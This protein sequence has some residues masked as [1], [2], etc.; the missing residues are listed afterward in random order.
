MS[1]KNKLSHEAYGGIN[2]ENYSPYVSVKDALPEL[3]IA[4]I[5][6]GCFFAAVFAAANVY[7][8]L[9]VGM[10][11]AAIIP[12]SILGTALLYLFGRKSILE[13][14]M[15]AGIA[16]IGE[17]LAGGIVFT[18]PAIVIWNGDISLL[19]IVTITILG[20]ILGI[21]FVIP[22]RKYL[23]VEEHGKLA[24]PESMAASEVLVNST[25]GGTGLKSVITG[26]AGGGI[27]K[28][29][30]GGLLLWSE[31]PTWMINISQN[32]KSIFQS[33]V[34]VDALASLLGVGFIV[35]TE[36]ALYMFAGGAIAYFGL[37]PLIK[38]FGSGA[39]AAV[40]PATVPI[41]E[42]TASAIRGEYIRYIGAGAVAAG[43]FISL[44]KSIPIIFR[45]MKAA[46]SGMKS[47]GEN[48]KRTDKDLPMTWVIG[49]AAL[50][51][52]LSWLLPIT[53]IHPVGAL[54][55][56]LFSFLFSVVSARICGII[57]ASNNP[58][59]GMTIATLLFITGI[60]KA[61][62]VVGNRGM[63]MALLAGAIA[64]VA[65]AVAGGT[66][67]ALK[68]TFILGGT[69]KNIELG[70]IVGL[71]VSA[72]AGGAAMLL[73][74]NI[75]GIGGE[76]GLQAPQATLMSMVV[77]GVMD[78]QLPWTLVLVGAAIGI[79]IE[80][81]GLPVLPVAL[82]IYLPINL[83]IGILAGG[84]VRVIV[85]KKF[86][87]DEEV[88]K[89]KVEKG[90]LISSGLVAGDALIGILV[91]ALTGFGLN[92]VVGI[93]PKFLPALAESKEFALVMF[94]ILIYL[95]YRYI[96]SNK[97]KESKAN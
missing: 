2:G 88:K 71:I 25:V 83:S 44:G 5:L 11:I 23:M 85:D 92:E 84:I 45:S 80:I 1:Q 3:T 49:G 43:G 55:A 57:G 30:S 12:T 36:A 87:H 95:V 31:S 77:Q 15:V 20:G 14:N 33:M 47:S 22:L 72:V 78:A 21:L 50:V 89:E 13:S 48:V 51:F 9:K 97:K 38:F 7:L 59:S 16:G 61:I 26:L 81:L 94:L 68:T 69:P 54:L 17:S 39:A 32:G 63:I 35:G 46:F 58:V 73:L 41:A 67:Q 42:M 76:T 19:Q 8:A 60:L 93:G 91:A 40:F 6:V 37:I 29:L 34:G 82:G 62:G 70:L 66:S 90:I 24:F 75:Y 74:I 86:K 64:C 52:L 10:T 28:F 4:S 65:T 27:Y 56:V 18:L 53:G 96:I 79:A